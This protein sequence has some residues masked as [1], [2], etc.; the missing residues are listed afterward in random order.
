MDTQIELIKKDLTL[1]KEETERR[2]NSLEETIKKLT[3]EERNLSNN[4]LKFEG[5]LTNIQDSIGRLEKSTEEGFERVHSR[6]D[7]TK[8]DFKAKQQR[9]LESYLAYKRIVI[10]A[11]LTAIVGGL[12]GAVLTSYRLFGG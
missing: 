3:G 5:I 8:D 12:M 7:S 6:I 10:G 11:V 1:F 2:I 4:I 9:E